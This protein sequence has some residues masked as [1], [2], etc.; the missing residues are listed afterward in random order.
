MTP[1]LFVL[2]ALIVVAII[3]VVLAS[4][5]GTFLGLGIL[6]WLGVWAGGI[7]LDM[8]LRQEWPRYTV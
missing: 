3:M 4:G 2:V 7:T 5:G 8:L 1:R 6:G